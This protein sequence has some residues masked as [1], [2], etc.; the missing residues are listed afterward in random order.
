MKKEVTQNTYDSLTQEEKNQIQSL[1]Q[2]DANFLEKEIIAGIWQEKISKKGLEKW[3]RKLLKNGDNIIKTNNKNESYIKIGEDKVVKFSVSS[4]NGFAHKYPFSAASAAVQ[5]VIKSAISNDFKPI[6]LLD[7]LR[8]GDFEEKENQ[9]KLIGIIKAISEFS[10]AVNIPVVGGE[11]FSNHSFNEIPIINAFSVAS[12]DAEEL[13]R[14]KII[15]PGYL[16]FLVGAHTNLESTANYEGEHSF[17]QLSN[18]EDI[19][20]YS[21]ENLQEK[22]LIDLCKNS[23]AERHFAVMKSIEKGGIIKAIHKIVKGKKGVD[24]YIDKIKTSIQKLNNLQILFSESPARALF[25]VNKK[26]TEK[27]T[28]IIEK[29]G[30]NCQ[31]IGEINDLNSIRIFE[32]GTKIAEIPSEILENQS[33]PERDIEYKAPDMSKV[34]EYSIKDIPLPEDLK[35]V[36]K[37]LLSHKNIASKRYLTKHFNLENNEFKSEEQRSDAAIVPFNDEYSLVVGVDCNS[38]YVNAHPQTGAAIAVAEAARN[39]VCSGGRPI[40]ISACINIGNYKNPEIF[41]QFT[42]IIK[43]INKVSREYNLPIINIKANFE[44]YTNVDGKEL[45]IYPTP[46]IGMLGTIR[47]SRQPLSL[48]FK[49]KGDMIFLLGETKNSIS[50]SL[51]LKSYH[52]VKNSPP[53]FFCLKTAH[54]LQLIVS[55]LFDNEYINSAHDISN[56]GLIVTLV[57]AALF[58]NLG[59][60]ITTDAENRNDAFLFGEAQNRIVVTVSPKYETDFID[61]MMEKEFPFLTLGHITRGDLRI[62]D[63]S[64]G[65]ILEIKD[66]YENSIEK[67]FKI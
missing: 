18:N 1:L 40:A 53:P 45:N 35:E 41:W 6:A 19:T 4:Q 42:E 57:E 44:N 7:S 66:L 11:I 33:I 32:N 65:N 34:K 46:T 64:W 43:G 48:S 60:D 30:L 13:K 55:E 61:F 62:D 23:Q 24:L 9:N 59:F 28:Q 22:L 52:K 26:N 63:V 54:K 17:N 16:I 38:R 12:I 56:G 2:R 31:S 10:K 49:Q 67:S 50:S 47:K 27:F 25:V 15:L 20:S 39:I 21:A 37:F 3:F 8:V 14:K 29:S 58:N 51:Y 36:G 5:N